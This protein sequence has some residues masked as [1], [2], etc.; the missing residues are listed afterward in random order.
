MNIREK[1]SI[2]ELRE[3]GI[4]IGF[5]FPLIIG[6]IIPS[7]SGHLFGYWTL[8]PGII[9]ILLGILRPEFLF[10]PYKLWMKLGD[11][12]GWINSRIILGIVYF[13]VLIPIAFFMRNFGYDPLRKIKS[14]KKTYREVKTNQK[15][16]LNRIF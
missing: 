14:K 12:L 1:K 11:L 10:V 7:L 9:L 2:K 6:W 13:F 5:I 4:V 3:F 15:I 8:Y 16:D